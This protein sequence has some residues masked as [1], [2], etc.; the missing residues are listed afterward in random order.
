MI[1][2]QSSYNKLI[3]NRYIVEEKDSK[4]VLNFDYVLPE[5]IEEDIEED[6]F[7]EVY[8]ESFNQEEIPLSEDEIKAEIEE[9]LI[10][11]IEDE[12][13]R[14]LSIAEDNAESLK[15]EAEKI[16]YEE[17]YNLAF[18]KGYKEGLDMAKKDMEGAKANALDLINQAETMVKDYIRENEKNILEL[19]VDM[20]ESIVEFSLDEYP[21]AILNMVRPVILEYSKK[22]KITIS[23]NE[24]RYEELKLEVE[25]LRDLYPDTKF[26]I[27][28]DNN[29]DKNDCIVECEDQLIDLSIKNQLDSIIN[30]IKY[31]E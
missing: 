30:T 18:D 16:G 25:E 15:K 14:I 7:E 27:F 26:F 10:R 11:E 2:I 13:N 20:A 8:D 3:K 28:K 19:A 9:K 12:R 17:G 6:F 22:E 5:I 24:F 23:C 21:E 1:K 4:K 31:M 29:L